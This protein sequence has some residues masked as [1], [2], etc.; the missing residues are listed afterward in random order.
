MIALPQR[1]AVK[2]VI[3]LAAAL[4]LALLVGDRNR[5]K[6]KAGQYSAH[7]AAERG[8][9]AATVAGYRAAAERARSADLANAE[10]V[11]SSQAQ[12]S[13]R[14]AYD[15]QS[16]I[17]AARARSGRLRGQA[18]ARTDSGGRA[19]TPV[20]RLSAAAGGASEAAGENGFPRSERLIATEQAIQLDE[21]IKWVKSQA[22]V[23]ANGTAD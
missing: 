21:L 3:A 1:L 6:S 5:W 7:L 16:R 20:P 13:E 19:A 17:T 4:M 10:R 23:E 9:H 12:I 8:A 2:L 14:T 11:K 22:A 18:G 15:Y